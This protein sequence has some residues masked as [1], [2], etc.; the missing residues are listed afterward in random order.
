MKIFQVTQ[1]T[2]I[3]HSE[4][5]LRLCIQAS[6]FA[7]SSGWTNPRLNNSVDPAPEDAV[8]DF[9]F[10]ADR[11]TG[12]ALPVLTPISASI[13]V[14]PSTGADA[15]IVSGRINSITVHASEFITPS[16][17]SPGPITT[18]AIGEEGPT[19]T[20]FAIGE[21]DPFPSTRALGEEGPPLTTEALGEEGPVPSTRAF[22]EEN[23]P[24]TTLAL[25]EEGPPITTLAIGEEEPMTDPRVD[26]PRPPIWGGPFGR[27]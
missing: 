19:F 10:D 23:P 11:P 18:L 12:I 4:S 26:N 14:A 25:G 20:T 24:F 27:Y 2:V 8:L 3:K 21:E 22:G 5:P 15:V 9:S 7:A 6:G 16:P 1:V 13:E 17:N